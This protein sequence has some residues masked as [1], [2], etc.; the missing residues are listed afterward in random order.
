MQREENFKF[1]HGCL[2]MLMGK[3]QKVQRFRVSGRFPASHLSK[4]KKKV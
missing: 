2:N 3:P 1:L 4:P